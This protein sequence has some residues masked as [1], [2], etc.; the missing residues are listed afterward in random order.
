VGKNGFV[1]VGKIVG[2]HGLKGNIKVYS[3]TESL[4]VFNSGSLILLINPQGFEKSYKI[5]WVKPHGNLILLSLKG[6]ENRNSVETLMGS[7]FFIE[8]INLP[9]LEDGSY[10]W[11][12]IIGISVFTAHDEYIGL[13]ESIIPTGSNDV[14]VVRNPN[15]AHDNETLI[16]AIESVILKIDLKRKTMRVDLPEGL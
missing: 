5:K 7:V 16:P 13:V 12:D 4:S 11:V 9:E 1:P 6:V 10:Y 15:K 14:F 3:Y 8:R 2:A